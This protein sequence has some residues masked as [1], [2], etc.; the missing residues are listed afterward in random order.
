MVQLSRSMMERYEISDRR[1][2]TLRAVIFGADARMLGAVAR[3]LDR[4]N[5]S[6]ADL[7]AAC[8]TGKAE[9]L[10]AQDGMFTMLIR[11]EGLDGQSTR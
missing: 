6:G 9:A 7:G 2:Q 1:P 5:E 10:S 3:M 4:A 8:V 11:G